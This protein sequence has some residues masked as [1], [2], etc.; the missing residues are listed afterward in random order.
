MKSSIANTGGVRVNCATCRPPHRC[1]KFGSTIPWTT[2]AEESVQS[3]QPFTTATLDPGG[4][5]RSH[6]HAPEGREAQKYG[7]VAEEINSPSVTRD[8]PIV[9]PPLGLDG[10]NCDADATD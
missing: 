5:T 4:T 8:D 9:T 2:E 7:G 6:E 1:H 3:S 10:G